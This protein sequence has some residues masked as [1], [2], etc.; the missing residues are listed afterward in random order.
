M[1][2]INENLRVQAWLD[3]TLYPLAS[4][5]AWEG[6]APE[7][8]TEPFIVYTHAGGPGDVAGAAEVRLWTIA[9]WFVTIYAPDDNY[10]ALV[11]IAD[12][13]DNALQLKGDILIGP[14]SDVRL[15]KCV[16]DGDFPTPSEV[17]GGITWTKKGTQW[18]TQAKNAAS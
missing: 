9:V 4:G 3:S 11:S 5:G 1:A 8:V 2:Y 7:S 17:I 13:V 6:V 12:A 18:R 10:T 14:N 16:R 15:I